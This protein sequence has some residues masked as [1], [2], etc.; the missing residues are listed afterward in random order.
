[1]PLPG[2]NYA[3]PYE[4]FQWSRLIYQYLLTIFEGGLTMEFRNTHSQLFSVLPLVLFLLGALT[5]GA[6]EGAL[7]GHETEKDAE[8]IVWKEVNRSPL[9]EA[10][11][12]ARRTGD[13]EKIRQIEDL[14][15]PTQPEGG[16]S[17]GGTQ[18]YPT[19]T[20]SG[21]GDLRLQAGSGLQQNKLTGPPKDFVGSDIKIRPGNFEH[22]EF[23]FVMASDSTGNL[24]T[25]FVDD[26][27]D[28]DYIQ[29]YKSENGGNSWTPFGYVIDSSADFNE[30]SI[31]V[32]E[33]SAGDTLLLAYIRDDGINMPVPEV[34]TTPLSSGIFTAHSVPVWSWE[35]YAKP[36][37]HTDATH[38]PGWYAYLTCEGIKQ[39]STKNINV[40]TWRSKDGGET[41]EDE[42]V[43]YG[44][45][46]DFEWIDPDI[47]FG[48]TLDRALIVT[49]NNDTLTLY[50][51]ASDSYGA[52]WNSSVIFYTLSL[53]PS[54]PVDPEIAAAINHDNVMVCCTRY[55]GSKGDDIG[56]GYS[57]DAGETWSNCWPLNGNREEDEFA[58]SLTANEGGGS[59]H[60]S[61]TSSQDHSVFYS[62]RPQDLSDL[63]QS[64]TDVIDDMRTAGSYGDYAKK[65][66]ASNWTTDVAHIVW[67]DS[68]D[69]SPG[70]YDGYSDFVGN[71]GLMVNET[72]ISCSVGGMVE[73]YLNVGPG[74]NDRDYILV[75]GLSGTSPGIPLPGGMATLPIKYDAFTDMTIR[76][77]NTPSFHNFMNT[78]CSSGYAKAT[79]NVVPFAGGYF[80]MYFAFAMN[81]PWDYA[82]NAVA[83]YLV[84]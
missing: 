63:W 32:G 37:I 75:G 13:M 72:M 51:M 53:L 43:N 9:V 24:Y 46:D 1:L 80:T 38:F 54:N 79:M 64:E 39:S 57:Q 34:A 29:V 50:T 8:S 67:S 20:V 27:Y 36:V 40:C 68:R 55:N 4:P 42:Y 26:Y 28:H 66:T 23:H 31:A 84:P 15:I 78:F 70:D 69:N 21:T 59:W 47:T 82:S 11:H 6:Q 61:F 30:P 58:A 74:G 19:Q 52:T 16:E 14:L 83:V 17:A 81:K 10:L 41:W 22:G 45:S 76:Y 7:Q 49:Y 71:D 77:A 60:L 5:A 3:L 62:K 25:A 65:G 33:G 35:G 56:Q 12:Q 48:T 18:L 2:C 73:F 44:N